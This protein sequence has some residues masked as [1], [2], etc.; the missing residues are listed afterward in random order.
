M[1]HT[2]QFYLRQQELYVFSIYNVL[3]EAVCDEVLS[4]LFANMNHYSLSPKSG[5]HLS[6]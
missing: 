3:Q 5:S 4:S 2:K 6:T 1:N